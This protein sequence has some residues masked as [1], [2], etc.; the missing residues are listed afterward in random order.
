MGKGVWDYFW[1]LVGEALGV[2]LAMVGA[3][4]AGALSGWLVDEKIFH[5]KTSPWF[6]IIGFALGAAGGIKNVFY[7]QKRMSKDREEK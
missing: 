3:V 4:L 7:F 5:G 6:T 1:E 2:G